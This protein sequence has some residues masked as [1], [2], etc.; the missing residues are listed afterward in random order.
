MDSSRCGRDVARYAV[1]RTSWV[2][3]GSLASEQVVGRGGP[4]VEGPGDTFMPDIANA[5]RARQAT[6]PASA[7]PSA[8]ALVRA[9]RR[10]SLVWLAVAVAVS[11]LAACSPS[12]PDNG[13]PVDL[14]FEKYTLGQRARGHPARG[15][16][17]ADRGG[18]P[19]VSRRPGQRGGGPHRL[20]APVR[21]HDVPGLGPRRSGRPHFAL[22]GGAS[23]R[24]ASTR[25]TDFDRTNYIEDVPSNQLEL[26]LWLESDRM[27]F[28]LDRPRPGGAVQ[29]AGRRA[30]RAPADHESAPYGLSDEA[31]YPPA[32]S[33]RAT[34]TTRRSSARTT[35][36]RRRSSRTCATSSRSYYVPNNASLAI[37]GDIDV[38]A[39]KAAG[40][41]VLR[42][43]PAGTRR[44]RAAGR[45][46]TA[47]SPPS[48]GST[49]TDQVELPRVTMAWVTPPVY[50][51]G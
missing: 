19:L 28:L 36:S 31:L 35:T 27:G 32:C 13:P 38:G 47:D 43:P 20:R 29:P 5:G 3:T 51:P 44:A 10:R 37:V 49:V 12:P 7:P 40:R 45:D 48:S 17:A 1:V 46:T 42:H 15:Q 25:T 26:A 41:E 30:Q 22:P 4:A 50:A 39:T 34:R 18:Q 8:W 14:Q 21:A 16:P 6:L 2:G 23:A 11:V 9:G 33:P 24:R